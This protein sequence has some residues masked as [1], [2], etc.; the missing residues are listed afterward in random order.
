[1]SFIRLA[2]F[3][4]GHRN[5][6]AL[7]SCQ[8]ATARRVSKSS[9]DCTS[10]TPLCFSA[11][12]L[13]REY[14]W[15]GEYLPRVPWQPVAPPCGAQST[16]STTLSHFDTMQTR[17]TCMTQTIAAF[18]RPVDRNLRRI[19]RITPPQRLRDSAESLLQGVGP[20]TAHQHGGLSMEK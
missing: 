5:L 17:S 8:P 3:S 1:M 20:R 15:L 19:S 9:N 2:D 14:H 10:H 16:L 12:S 13:W 4:I 11:V 7:H 6:D 18:R